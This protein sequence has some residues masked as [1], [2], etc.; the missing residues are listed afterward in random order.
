MLLRLLLLTSAAFAADVRR[1]DLF[2]SGSEG[3]AVYRIPGIVATPAGTLL[4]YAEARRLNAADWGSIDLVMRRSEDGGVTWSAQ[5]VIARVEG[6][7]AQNPVARVSRPPDVITYNNPVAI[8]DRRKGV[9]H[10]L[11]CVEY[12]RVFYMRSEDDGRT[13]GKPVEITAAFE[14]FRP[15][16]NWKVVATGPGHGIQLRS[17]RLLVPVWL[18]T[19][20]DNAHHP[21]VVATIYSD[22]GGA[23]WK[24]GAIA[25]S[26][27]GEVVNPNESAAVQLADGR[28]MLNVRST[29]APHRRIVMTSPDGVA[30]W[31]APR[32]QP[33]LL[34][35]VCFGS[36]IAAGRR[37]LL[38]VNPHDDRARRNLLVQRSDDNGQTWKPEVVLEPG[39]A[40]YADIT[41][42]P[43][44]SIFV[45]YE[46]GEID[47]NRFR[48]AALTLAEFKLDPVK[49]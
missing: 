46:R 23:T 43:R 11:F 39:W 7:L 38:F 49:E 40:G 24:R 15:E 8:A 16:Y 29:S 26:G 1:T 32:F 17:G 25:A 34:E 35:P 14:A 37:T 2:V 36:I 42:G 5:R 41:P 20:E 44:N 4:A 13:F 12:M 47:P 6:E 45:L 31:T 48:I 28:V 22:D 9:V 10:F 18:S 27:G 21:N 19:S 33:E 3:Y 30:G